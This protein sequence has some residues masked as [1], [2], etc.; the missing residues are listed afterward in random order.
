MVRRNGFFRQDQRLSPRPQWPPMEPFISEAAI[1]SFMQWPPMAEKSGSLKPADG[2]IHHRHW[3]RMA[4]SILGHGTKIFTHSI[5]TV[6]RNGNVR[7]PER[8]CR[9]QRSVA[10]AEYVSARVTRNSTLWTSRETESGI[11]KRVARS[12]HRRQS[13]EMNACI[14]R[15]WTVIYMC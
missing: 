5:R 6:R 4:Q 9:R 7:Q 1:G 10:M 2:W 8:L 12:F 14:L 13:T 11:M 3:A 15:R